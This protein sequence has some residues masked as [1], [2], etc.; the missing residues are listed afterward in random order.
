MDDTRLRIG[1]VAR[2]A[3]V[4]PKAIRFYE[5]KGL[6]PRP[7]RAANG[8]RL[9][10]RDAVDLLRFIKQAQGL[11]LTLD[12]IR[13]IVALRQ[14]G[15]PPCAHVYRLLQTKAAELDRKLSDL[16]T[17]RRR[18]RQSLAAWG[19]RPVGRA[20]VCPHIENPRQPLRRRR[21]RET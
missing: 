15:R 7:P 4:G 12:E 14:G 5:A 20:A 2:Q 18:I 6:I 11:G 8:Y 19:R 1:V 3:G 21:R 10:P 17:L 9:Y 16:L 13:E